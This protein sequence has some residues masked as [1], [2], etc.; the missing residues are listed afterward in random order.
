MVDPK[1]ITADGSFTLYNEEYKEH[2]HSLVGAKTEASL[3]YLN[4]YLSWAAKPKD[5]GITR[6]FDP[7]F[8]L[9]FNSYVFLEYFLEKNLPIII[10]AIEID[11]KLAPYWA[12]AMAYFPSLLKKY[13]FFDNLMQSDDFSLKIVDLLEG[14]GDLKSNSYDVILHDAFTFHKCPE[15][16]TL[17]LFKQYKELLKEK[18][19][20]VTYSSSKIVRAGLIEAGFSLKETEPVGR[21]RGGTLAIKGNSEPSEE[22]FLRDYQEICSSPYREPLEEIKA[23]LEERRRIIVYTQYLERRAKRKAERR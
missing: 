1:K 17:D 2:Y 23:P 12:P 9:G 14:I 19:V 13:S 5:A 11:E 18:G 22:L 4:P 10:D 7:F 16:W 3:K 8:G 6:V 15:L 20:I 21:K